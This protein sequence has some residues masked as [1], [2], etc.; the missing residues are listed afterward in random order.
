MHW[1]VIR[2]RNQSEHALA[3]FAAV[4]FGLAAPHGS[5][6]QASKVGISRDFPSSEVLNYQVTMNSPA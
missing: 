4:P 6:I 2:L 3:R 1:Q 5:Y